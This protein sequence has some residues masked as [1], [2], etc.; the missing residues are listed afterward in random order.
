MAYGGETSSVISGSGKKR[1]GGEKR[2][3]GVIKRQRSGSML[4]QQ[5]EPVRVTGHG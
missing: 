5:R 4:A 1:G 3:I 2:S